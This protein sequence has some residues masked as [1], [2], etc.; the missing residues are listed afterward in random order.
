MY[1]Q[2]TRHLLEKDLALQDSDEELVN[3]EEQSGDG[4]TNRDPLGSDTTAATQ[5][6]TW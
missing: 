6:P 1:Y 2:P 5:V 4:S 3:A